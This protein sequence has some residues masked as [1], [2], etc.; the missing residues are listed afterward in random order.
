VRDVWPLHDRTGA[1]RVGGRQYPFYGL[2]RIMAQLHREGLSVNRK[3]VQL[4]TWE[5]VSLLRT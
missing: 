3:A 4:H 2:R 5:S 1:P